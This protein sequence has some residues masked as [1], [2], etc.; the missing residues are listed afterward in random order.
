M[1]RGVETEARNDEW[2]SSVMIIARTHVI[3][4]V[5]GAS[6]RQELHMRMTRE[7]NGLS[8]DEKNIKRKLILS[9]SR[10]FSQN[11]LEISYI[12]YKNYL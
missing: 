10:A 8:E 3:M 7:E 4:R 1:F 5:Y 6:T 9:L 2:S 11:M 12:N